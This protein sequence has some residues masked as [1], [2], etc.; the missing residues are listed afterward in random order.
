MFSSVANKAHILSESAPH[1]ASWLSVVPSAALGLHLEPN[2]F[3]VALKWWLGHDLSSGLL[4]PLCPDTALDPVGHHAVTCRQGG[5]VVMRHNQLRGVIVDFCHSARLGV[6]V[7]FGSELTPYPRR[8]RPA[9]SLVADWERGRPAVWDASPLTPAVLNEAGMTAAAAV[10]ASE[11]RKH[12]VNDPKCQELGWVCVPL[13][14]E[15]YGNWGR[16][17]HTTFTRLATRLAIC[18]SPL[19]SKVTADLFGRLSLVLTRSIARVILTR[20]LLQSFE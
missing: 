16:E 1:S 11:Q 12:I 4:C 10:A 5:D 6:K 9:D 19:I 13:T 3:L 14:V 18:V 15:T 17:A 2:E 20:S 7:E 8:T